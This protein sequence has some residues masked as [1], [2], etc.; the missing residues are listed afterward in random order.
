MTR[1]RMTWAILGLVA[2]IA[3]LFFL[4]PMPKSKVRAQRIQSVNHLASVTI[5]LPGTN[6]L[7][8]ATGNK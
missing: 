4:P 1:R 3:L 6:T 5:T 7:P 8:A 2:V